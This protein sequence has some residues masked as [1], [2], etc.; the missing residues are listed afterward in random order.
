MNIL[1]SS[2]L[3]KVII[4]IGLVGKLVIIIELTDSIHVAVHMGF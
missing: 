2:T 3:I 4:E 1:V